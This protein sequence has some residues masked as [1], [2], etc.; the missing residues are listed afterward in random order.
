[1]ELMIIILIA[2]KW[3]KLFA[4]NFIN[5]ISLEINLISGMFKKGVLI[6]LFFLCCNKNLFAQKPVIETDT[7]FLAK[8]KGL[9][10]QLGKS[11]NTNDNDEEQVIRKN[12]FIK[13]LGKKIRDIKIVV[14]GFERNIADTTKI[15]RSIGVG[16][17]NA[18]HKNSQSK[19]IANNLFF[20]SGD[21]LNPFLMADNERHLREQPFIQDALIEVE[22]IPGKVDEID[23]LVI[24][25][26]VF[27]LGAGIDFASSKKIKM[28]VKEENLG[29]TGAK[30]ALFSLYDEDRNPKF[31]YGLEYLNR[32]IN[33]SFLNWLVGFKSFN[34]AFNSGRNEE[35]TFYTSFERPLV[36]AYI[37]WIGALDISIN[38]TF[39]N[40]VS[41]SLYKSDFKYS[42]QKVDGWL[43]Y[44]LGSQKLL[45]KNI[46][47][48]VRKFIAVRTLYQHFS[49]LPDEVQRN[50]DYR[51]TNI[52]GVLGSVSVL[53][54][55]FYRANFIYGFGRNED[56]PEGFN[57]SLIGGWVNK[58]DSISSNFRS[59]PY[60]AV[61][62]LRSHFN[63]KGF[64]STYTL[65]MGG[66]VYRGRWEDIDILLNVDRFSK[67][68][69]INS[70]WYYRQFYSASLTRQFNPVLNQPLFINS[71]FGLPYFDNG[72]IK[73][74][75]RG[76]LKTESVFY[77]LKKFA[78]FR[79][80]PFVFVDACFIK[81]TSSSFSQSDLFT[82]LGV[83]FRTRNEN[84]VFGTIEF[85][86]FY[87]PR[88][89]LG[90]GNWR[91]QASTNVRF[92]YN[93]VFIKKPDFII[94]N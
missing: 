22:K 68:N 71:N 85:K 29:G 39:N 92:K 93:S 94:A 75:L 24:V 12:P 64:F 17:A 27:S 36:S 1:M 70:R 47:S 5:S 19:V 73:A 88:T 45:R 35:A 33:G 46:Q 67:K 15:N 26:D 38:S 79:F 2:E 58:K 60:Y 20:V 84:L 65:R 50:F 23:I 40:Y 53:K 87:F 80:A 16:I 51:Y 91:V 52:T 21:K 89:I 69:I 57:V 72:N 30:L 77:N 37:P 10:G 7:F 54:Q 56:L 49:Q 86:G 8:K 82:A 9:M 18:F 61:E 11:L 32:N 44:N 28:D 31:G 76:A 14:L 63:K 13:H 66:F 74:D 6:F 4:Y 81:P 41:D 42:Y 90:M 34:N 59:R 78:G 55:N 62:A 3:I 25:K 83:G 43:G 48:R